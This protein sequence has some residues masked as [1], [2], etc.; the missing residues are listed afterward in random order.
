MHGVGAR[1]RY[2]KAFVAGAVAVVVFHQGMLA[3]LHAAGMAQRAPFSM[4]PTAP[5]GV[6][7][8]VSLAFWGGLWGIVL[9]LAVRGVKD[10]GAW[11]ATALIVGTVAT[12]LVAWFVVAP[13]KQ[14][15]IGGGWKPAA[16]ATALL[17]NG[18][19]A[20]GTAILLRAF[21]ATR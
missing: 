8:L 6:P 3:L 5:F 16:M 10:T 17:V 21:R 13:I 14:Q 9:L 4:E 20:L 1:M 2:L 18:A 19:W 12:T 15:P 11:W 7:Q